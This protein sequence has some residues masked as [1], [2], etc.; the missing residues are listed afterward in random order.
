M[1]LELLASFLGVASLVAGAPGNRAREPQIELPRNGKPFQLAFEHG[2]SIDYVERAAVAQNDQSMLFVVGNNRTTDMCLFG[3]AKDLN[4]RE[5]TEFG[6]KNKKAFKNGVRIP[7]N[8]TAVLGN[9]IFLGPDGHY[10]G[11]LY[12]RVGCNKHCEKCNGGELP[13]W[14]L[15]E[16]AYKEKKFWNNLSNVDGVSANMTTTI[17]NSTTECHHPVQ[18]NFT[19]E[20][21]KKVCPPENFW[22]EG[23]TF[24]CMSDCKFKG[25]EKHCGRGGPPSDFNK[26]LCPN[27]YFWASDDVARGKSHV[28]NDCPID[29]RSMKILIQ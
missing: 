21:A 23:D 7:S 17:M 18:C 15:S 19:L 9:M 12:S 27:A 14:T 4:S 28:M 20:Q 8:S 16:F 29:P 13:I 2:L 1:R 24:G 26:H 10:N 22:K 25:G 3:R 6:K 5:S 11:M